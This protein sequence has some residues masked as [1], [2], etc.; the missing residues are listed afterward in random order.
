M[1]KK[2]RTS[3]PS[4][5]NSLTRDV[6]LGHFARR[7]QTKARKT[8]VGKP[9][10]HF[11]NKVFRPFPAVRA[12]PLFT[13]KSFDYLYKSAR[14]Y[15][16]QLGSSFDFRGK[17]QNDF[18]RLFRYFEKRL[19][20]NQT[21]LLIQQEQK[22]S[23]KISFSGDFLIGEVFFIPI[24]I[25]RGIEGTFREIVLSF[26]QYLFHTHRFQKKEN[27]Y[28]Y[29]M[30]MNCHFDEWNRTDDE[31]EEEVQRYEDFLIAYKEGYIH[32][33]FS[34]IYQKPAC[35]LEE[36][37]AL[38]DNY[39][40][41]NREEKN[42]LTTIREGTE[43]IKTG[44]DIFDYAYR[45]KEGDDNF[46]HIDEEQVIDA[47]RLLRFVYSRLDDM[48]SGYLEYLE[49]ESQEAA[50][51]YF[52][53]QFLLLT[54]DNASLIGDGFVEC[55]FTWLNEFIQKLHEYEV[56]QIKSDA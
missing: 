15:S 39:I 4:G 50:N 28:D 40:P 19:P 3:Q 55:F 33:T 23:F 37:T 8:A 42:V 36:L 10:N 47:E 14:N 35:S 29:D 49:C 48:S 44:K 46:Y 51:E 45:P 9:N 17:K 27:S 2:S 18:W 54:P 6:P 43:I 1:R 16:K 24:K 20:H 26:F 21:L 34:L 53:C 56:L 13:D 11:L 30:I 41:Q 22:L 38:T 52:P 25:L 7:K 5:T 12:N 32:D 31:D